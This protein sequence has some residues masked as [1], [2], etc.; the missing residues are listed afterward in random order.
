MMDDAGFQLRSLVTCPWNTRSLK[1]PHSQKSQG[2]RF[3]DLAGQTFENVHE[4]TRTSGK[5]G[6]LSDFTRIAVCAVVL[7]CMNTV[8]AKLY[9]HGLSI[10]NILKTY[11]RIMNDRT[12]F[13][14]RNEGDMANELRLIM[15]ICSTCP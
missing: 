2:F 6:R 5:L 8:L 14:D 7:S 13:I 10:N 1:K 4:M 11:R 3:G 12:Q 9:V 15:Y